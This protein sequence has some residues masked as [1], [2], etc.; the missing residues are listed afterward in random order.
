MDDELHANL[1]GN[2]AYLFEEE[3]EVAAQL[4]GVDVLVAVERLLELF[5][6]EALLRAGQAGN[7]VARQAVFVLVAHAG[8]A[9]LCLLDFLG[10]VVLLGA[11]ALEDEEVEC[12]EGGT[13]E[14]QSA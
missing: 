13:L 4:F 5:D 8:E 7:H 10:C 3:D 14:A 6:G 9:C 2:G 12:H 1:V 11:R